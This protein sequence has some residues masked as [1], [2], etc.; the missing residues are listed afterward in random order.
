VLRY[1]LA[2]L[3][4]P[5][6]VH[7]DPESLRAALLEDSAGGSARAVLVDAQLLDEPSCSGLKR[8]CGAMNLGRLVDLR[9][10][11][12]DP[13]GWAAHELPRPLTRAR[14]QRWLETG[15]AP[16]V[17]LE[18]A[19]DAAG[20]ERELGRALRVLLVEDV[21]VNQMVARSKL[22]KLGYEVDLADNGERAVAAVEAN[23][24]SVVLMDIQ[25]PVM[26]GV[27]ATRRIRNLNNPRKAEV[28]VIALTAHAMKG[29]EE[30]YLSAGMNAYLTKPIENDALESVMRRFA[31][32]GLR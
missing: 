28:P 16:A 27:E 23:E 1:Q 7:Q 19:G 29:A 24:Y 5:L 9:G 32:M 12:S 15:H 31:P 21:R 14:L 3:G 2:L 30:E 4:H 8:D 6:R 26:D 10:S 25:M 17:E 11:G 13:H 20:S 18:D 22:S